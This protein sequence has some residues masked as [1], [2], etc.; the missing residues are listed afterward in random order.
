MRHDSE[1]PQTSRLVTEVPVPGHWLQVLATMRADSFTCLS[2]DDF[3]AEAAHILIVSPTAEV[4]LACFP[5]LL[6]S[7][8]AFTVA[9]S[10]AGDEFIE[11]ITAEAVVP[12]QVPAGTWIFLPHRQDGWT[13]LETASARVRSGLVKENTAR[14][15]DAKFTLIEYGVN[16]WLWAEPP[17]GGGDPVCHAGELISWESAWALSDTSDTGSDDTGSGGTGSS[18]AGSDGSGNSARPPDV[19]TRP[20]IYFGLPTVLRD[21]RRNG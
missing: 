2:L 12:E 19:A 7:D 21:R 14:G 9:D 3:R 20:P 10:G 17:Y 8:G 15:R 1:R 5:D 18:G 13:Q 4:A 16:L 11:I 6:D